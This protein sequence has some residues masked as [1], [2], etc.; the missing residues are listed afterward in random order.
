M[1]FKHYREIFEI[2]IWLLASEYRVTYF[3][4]DDRFSYTIWDKNT[5]EEVAHG[6]I[7]STASDSDFDEMIS[8]L[9]DL[10]TEAVE[11]RR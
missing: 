10:I 2:K 6:E 9:S 4:G 11:A 7:H 5:G 8:R 1:T 3:A